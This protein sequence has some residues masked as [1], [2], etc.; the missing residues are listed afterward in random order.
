MSENNYGGPY[1]HEDDAI[2]EAYRNDAIDELDTSDFSQGALNLI[3]NLK[4]LSGD[5]AIHPS[6]DKEPDLN[7][8]LF[9]LDGLDN[10]GDEK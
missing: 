3:A 6:E 1:A 2:N 7:K 5:K 8:A 10:F 9:D 4:F